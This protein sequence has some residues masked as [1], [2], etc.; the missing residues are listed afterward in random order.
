MKK[1]IAIS[2]ILV[3]LST[4]AFAQIGADIMVKGN[5]AEGSNEEGA[6]V[7]TGFGFSRLR[8]SGS[9]TNDEETFGGHIRAEFMHWSGAPSYS[10]F[11]WWKPLDVLKIQLGE[12]QDGAFGGVDGV[13]RWGFYRDATDVGVQTENWA[14]SNS[15][16]GGWGAQG[17]GITLTPI[18]ALAINIGI[19]LG[20]GDTAA[21]TFKKTNAQVV[22]TIDGLGKAAITYVGG[23][24][25]KDW[26][27]GK[28]GKLTVYN[29][30]NDTTGPNGSNG[31]GVKELAIKAI[32]PKLESNDPSKIFAFFGL[33]AIENLDLAIGIGYKFGYENKGDGT[34]KVKTAAGDNVPTP[35]DYGW[36]DHDNNPATD[37]EWGPI[38]NTGDPTTDGPYTPKSATDTNK[39]EWKASES[40]ADDWKEKGILSVG[41]SAQYDAGAFGVKARVQG[42]ILGGGSNE[43]TDAS[44]TKHTVE[45]NIS[46][47]N[48]RSVAIEKAKK[49]GAKADAIADLEKA[50]AMVNSFTVT[51][52]VLP[53]YAVNDSLTIFLSAGIVFGGAGEYKS[54]STPSGGTASTTTITSNSALSWHAQPLVTYSAGWGKT[55]YAG[56][57][58][59]SSPERTTETKYEGGGSSKTVKDHIADSSIKWSIPIGLYISF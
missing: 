7:K 28:D 39:T 36:V 46:G 19:P 44:G 57:R 26:E 25:H 21:D 24:G 35:P 9:A 54:T 53:Y 10:G 34:G 47:V 8:L 13:A 51:F 58:L 43:Y 59:E 17:L 48:E 11:A 29:D 1:L 6:E 23:A 20:T 55:F 3:L 37:P 32:D 27:A 14:F 45:T 22:Y 2:V 16:Y 30:P 40:K 49:A 4:A 12:D 5:L 38:P 42:D 41:L 52:D 18:E 31:S 33:T 50:A 56:F 15:F